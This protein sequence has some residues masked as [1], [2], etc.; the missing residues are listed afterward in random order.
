MVV[1]FVFAIFSRDHHPLNKKY[2]LY[3]LIF[4]IFGGTTP[5]RAKSTT[6]TFCFSEF[7]RRPPQKKVLFV[8]ILKRDHPKLRKI[9]KIL[10]MRLDMINLQKIFGKILFV[11]FVPLDLV[12]FVFQNFRVDHPK[13]C[14]KYLQYFLIF[15]FFEETT[16]N[17]T[18][19]TFDTFWFSD[20][21]R[22]PPKIVQKV[23]SI[24]FDFALRARP[25][26]HPHVWYFML[27][28]PPALAAF[29]SILVVLGTLFSLHSNQN[30]HAA[31][32]LSH[33]HI[34]W[35]WAN[36]DVPFLRFLEVRQKCGKN[37]QYITPARCC[38]SWGMPQPLK[39][40]SLAILSK[41]SQ[42]IKCVQN[43]TELLKITI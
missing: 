32:L 15:E 6:W 17:R 35:V 38:H 3:F 18:K 8:N 34:L 7:S 43:V 28:P 33:K 1:L 4:E 12:L 27:R 29:T 9:Y 14:K 10:F 40:A 5:N 13:S 37:P 11:W 24:L 39:T 30:K 20:F 21:P 42:R 26:P 2:P 41:W 23:P 22:R 16:Q 36:Y 31:P 25:P 19:S